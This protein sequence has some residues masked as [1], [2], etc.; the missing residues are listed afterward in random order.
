MPDR[1][2]LVGSSDSARE[3][4]SGVRHRSGDGSLELDVTGLLWRVD[5]ELGFGVDSDPVELS[6]DM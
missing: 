6:P 5:V 2:R 1:F 3:E 4:G